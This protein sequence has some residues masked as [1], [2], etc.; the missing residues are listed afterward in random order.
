[1]SFAAV[2]IA[3]VKRTPHPHFGNRKDSETHD[4]KDLI[5]LYKP[6]E[7]TKLAIRAGVLPR[8]LDKEEN[9]TA[10]QVDENHIAKVVVTCEP[11]GA[12]LMMGAMHPKG[13]LYER[14]VNMADAKATH[15][16]FRELLRSNGCKVSL[17]HGA[18]AIIMFCRE[19]DAAVSEVHVSSGRRCQLHCS[20]SCSGTAHHSL[21]TWRAPLKFTLAL[22]TRTLFACR[23]G[24]DVVTD[25]EV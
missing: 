14:P 15:A 24:S 18:T 21:S 13:S 2:G 17:V 8:I 23:A 19:G 4:F 25:P 7:A 3:D 16:A 10:I 22:S 6:D 11:E 20:G 1:M 12:S 5:A 9:R